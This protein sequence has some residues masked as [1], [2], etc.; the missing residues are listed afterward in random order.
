MNIKLTFENIYPVQHGDRQRPEDAAGE[1]YMNIY[2]YIYV[3]IHIYIH[4]HIYICTCMHVYIYTCVYV[5][6]DATGDVYM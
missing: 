2:I 5:Y 1:I 4:I 6:E 3:Y